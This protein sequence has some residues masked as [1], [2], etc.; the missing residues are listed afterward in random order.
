MPSYAPGDGVQAHQLVGRRLAARVELEPGR[1]PERSGLHRLVDEALHRRH[2]LGARRRAR[3]ARGEPDRVVADEPGEVR[4]VA[5]VRE[6]LEVLAEGRP[7]DRRLVEPERVQPAADDG[8][9]GRRHGRVAPAAVAD[10]LGRDA[11]ADRAL[12]GRVRED[13]EVAVAVRV[14]EPRADDLAGRVDDAVGGRRRA[15]PADVGDPAALDR[16]VAE[17][18]RAA[19]AVRDPAVPDQ[20][21]EHGGYFLT[22]MSPTCGP[23]RGSRMSRSP[24]P[25]RLKPSTTIMI[26]APG[27]ID[28][29]GRDVDV[30]SRGA[31]HAAPRGL[32]R[33]RAEPEEAE[34]R[35]GQDRDRQVDRDEHEQRRAD[36]RDHVAHHDPPAARSERAGRLGVRIA[37]HLE[38]GA[39]H[40]PREGGQ[41]H[42]PD[43]DHRVPA[44]RAEQAGDHDRED[45][46]GQREHD[47]DDAHQHRVDDPLVVAGQQAE[48]DPAHE[49]DRDGDQ[50]RRR[51][52]PAPR[53]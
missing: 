11:L 47:V 7:R 48:H 35:L 16:D 27:K 52:R 5:D 29:H 53:G 38:H 3:H 46:P 20:D 37:H 17:E 18:R 1:H 51:A 9:G 32:R 2:L 8:L 23:S 25:R 19:G 6:E 49:G 39:A 26:A 44:V 13:R 12:G 31:Q 15:E 14:D 36:V 34:R 30:G 42:D 24:S 40:D 41:D 10:D 43:R 4:R 22:G 45:D 50:P 28:S 33:L 21:V